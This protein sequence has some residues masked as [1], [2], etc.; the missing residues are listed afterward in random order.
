M[1]YI[2]NN[3]VEEGSL[4]NRVSSKNDNLQTVHLIRTI[5]AKQPSNLDH[6][7]HT[8]VVLVEYCFARYC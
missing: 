2:D 4:Q 8:I 5:F 7:M 6:S 3:I 1:I